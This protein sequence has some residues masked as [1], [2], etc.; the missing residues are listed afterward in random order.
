[1][2]YKQYLQSKTTV[3]PDSQSRPDVP[4]HRMHCPISWPGLI[5]T[6][7]DEEIQVKAWNGLYIK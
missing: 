6:R 5:E 2:L 7:F 4:I 3:T 1:M